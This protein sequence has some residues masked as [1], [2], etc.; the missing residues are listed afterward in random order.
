MSS[1]YTRMLP[2]VLVYISI[3]PVPLAEIRLTRHIMRRPTVGC[4]RLVCCSCCAP[5][6]GCGCWSRAAPPRCSR[7][8]WR[9]CLWRSI[10]ADSALHSSALTRTCSV[11]YTYSRAIFVRRVCMQISMYLS[12]IHFY[13]IRTGTVAALGTS[14]RVNGPIHSLKSESYAQ[15]PKSIHSIDLNR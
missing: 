2:T 12:Y 6:S 11:Q 15:P 9:T 7:C 10:S 13:I 4:R 8:R 14:A 3:Q 5:R 1:V